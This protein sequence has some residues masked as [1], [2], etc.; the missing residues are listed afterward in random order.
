MPIQASAL[1]VLPQLPSQGSS[2]QQQQNPQ[3]RTNPMML[4]RTGQTSQ[5]VIDTLKERTIHA[6]IEAASIY[7]AQA[8]YSQVHTS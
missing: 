2:S 8:H 5:I 4:A 3:A 1:S 6:R 7:A